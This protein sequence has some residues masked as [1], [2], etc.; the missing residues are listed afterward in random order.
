[1][2]MKIAFIGD[3]A[4]WFTHPFMAKALVWKLVTHYVEQ[5][6]IEILIRRR[7]QESVETWIDDLCK[8]TWIPCNIID[9]YLY[10]NSEAILRETTEKIFKPSSLVVFIYGDKP[11]KIDVWL[12]YECICDRHKIPYHVYRVRDSCKEIYLSYEFEN[13]FLKPLEG[14]N[15]SGQSVASLMR[16]IRDSIRQSMNRKLYKPPPL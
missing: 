12:R 1:M 16:S 3:L 10:T 2:V 4:K 8:Q 14:F 13:S 7:K 6:D 11:R 5:D 9:V 15:L